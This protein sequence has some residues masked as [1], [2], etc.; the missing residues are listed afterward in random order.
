MGEATHSEPQQP[1]HEKAQGSAQHI[2]G[3]IS[4]VI[5][6]FGESENHVD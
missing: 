3:I 6:E 4:F 1:R 5:K 2:Q